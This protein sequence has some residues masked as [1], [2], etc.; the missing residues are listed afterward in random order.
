MLKSY[1]STKATIVYINIK[2]VS[3]EAAPGSVFKVE[4]TDEL[5]ALVATGYLEDATSAEK[6]KKAKK[7]KDSA[8]TKEVEAADTPDAAE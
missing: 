1:L 6:A 2:G 4:E 3:K 7:V 8:P 5:E